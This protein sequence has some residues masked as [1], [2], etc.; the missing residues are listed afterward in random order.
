MIIPIVYMMSKMHTSK[1]ETIIMISYIIGK[2][3]FLRHKIAIHFW[4]YHLSQIL[5]DNCLIYFYKGCVSIWWLLSSLYSGL[6]KACLVLERWYKINLQHHL[7]PDGHPSMYLHNSKLLN[8]SWCF[9]HDIDIVIQLLGGRFCWMA[10]GR[11]YSFWLPSGGYY[12]SKIWIDLHS[13]Y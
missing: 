2:I 3:Y 5:A 7:C 9:Q 6:R 4:Y 8:E 13:A 12:I 10:W 1:V 11:D